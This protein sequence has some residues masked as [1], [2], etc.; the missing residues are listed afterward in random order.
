MFIIQVPFH[1]RLFIPDGF[2]WIHIGGFLGGIPAEENPDKRA[3]TETHHDAPPLDEDGHIGSNLDDI[4]RPD[5]Q[6]DAYYASR[7]TQYGSFDE[8]LFKIN[9][10]TKLD[11]GH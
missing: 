11:L 5:T 1:S 9:F 2:D 6:Y 3:D 7:D 8:E 10:L 4:C